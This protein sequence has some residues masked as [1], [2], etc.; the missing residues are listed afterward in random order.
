MTHFRIDVSRGT[1]KI[2]LWTEAPCGFKPTIGW[3]RLEGVKEFAEMLLGFYEIRKE[4]EERI[5][6][7]SNGLLKQALGDDENLQEGTG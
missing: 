2:V 5:K 4:E 6:R 1:G 3:S 7:I